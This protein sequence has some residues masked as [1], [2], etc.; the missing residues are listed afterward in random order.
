M[1]VAGSAALEVAAVAA[2][3]ASQLS[4]FEPPQQKERTSPA[5]HCGHENESHRR[6]SSLI[7]IARAGV[8]HQSA[9][10]RCGFP[11]ETRVAGTV[12]LPLREWERVP[13]CD[14]RV[15]AS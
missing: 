15:R 10:R 7:A 2:S 4:P 5:D 11:D 12:P 1:A 6:C 8:Q 13:V 9:G 3:A 14:V